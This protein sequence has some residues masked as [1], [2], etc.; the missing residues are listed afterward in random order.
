VYYTDYTHAT[1]WLN[2]CTSADNFIQVVCVDTNL[3]LKWRKFISA[4][5]GLC[6]RTFRI[7]APDGRPGALISGNRVGF[8]DYTDTTKLSNFLYYVD[9]TG[10]P[11][12]IGNNETPLLRDQITLYPNPAQNEI[13]VDDVF[14]GITAVQVYNAQG[15]LIKEAH[16]VTGQ[17]QAKMNLQGLAQGLLLIRVTTADQESKVFRIMKH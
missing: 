14:G 11:V 4:G 13:T 5:A 9:S 2:D 15:Q 7:I 6:A 10:T 1:G 16:S 8:P 17:R 3:N 12:G